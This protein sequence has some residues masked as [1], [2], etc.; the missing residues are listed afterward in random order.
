MIQKSILIVFVCLFSLGVKAQNGDS[1]IIRKIADDV[2]INGTAYENLRYLCKKIGPRLSGSVQAQKA[3]EAT[4]KMLKEAGADTVYLQPCMVPHWV[5]GEKE[6]GYIQVGNMPKYELHLC[7]LGNSEGT[8]KKG[9]TAGVVEVKSLK[10]LDELGG[11]VIK[12]KIVFFNFAMNPA[13]IQTFKAY[14]TSG[15]ARRVGPSK[16][17]SYGAIGVMVRSLASNFDDYPHTGATQYNDSFPKIP[18]VAISTNDAEWL[19][20]QLKLK[21]PLTA[22]FTNTSTMLADTMSY[23]V[24][25]EI[26]G[27]E[28]PKEIITVGGHLDSWDLAEG[29]QDDGAGATQS[30][31]VLRVLKATGIR[32]KRT[33]R[34]VMFMNEENGGRGGEKYLELAEKNKETHLFALESDA[35]GFTPRGFSL[36]MNGAQ[37]IKI[38]Q[39]KNLFYPYGVYDFSIGYSGA[40]VG[41]LKKVGAAMAGLMPD[42]QRYFDVH[43]AATDV[44]ENVSKRELNLGAINMAALIYLVDNYGLN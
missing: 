30:I 8:G 16:A 27:S 6:K 41:P 7:A 29:A 23:N 43:H 32:P 9:I 12:G 17:A 34:A 33:I 24:V 35:G 21:M 5:R 37:V 39:W 1:I 18:A 22:S 38:Q 15:V 20:K 10:E 36:E 11:A 44:F 13:F 42:S 26:T 40:D 3:V 14:S 4:A 28:F 25:G 19:S 31:E 2:L